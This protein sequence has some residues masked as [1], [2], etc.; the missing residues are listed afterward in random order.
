MKKFFHHSYVI[1]ETNMNLNI[2]PIY[3]PHLLF[4]PVLF[5]C[6][7]GG[8][9]TPG[10]EQGFSDWIFGEVS[11]SLC[12]TQYLIQSFNLILFWFVWGD[13]QSLSLSFKRF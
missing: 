7:S 4:S 1:F 9:N 5:F 3:F 10:L 2:D 13:Y 6:F 8:R 12:I 11:G